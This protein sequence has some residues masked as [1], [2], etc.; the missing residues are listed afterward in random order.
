[1]IKISLAVPVLLMRGCLSSL[2]F[3]LS[4]NNAPLLR[5]LLAGLCFPPLPLYPAERGTG[6]G[7]EAS[8]HDL[9]VACTD[10]KQAFHLPQ[11][12][13]LLSFHR[14]QRELIVFAGV[15]RVLIP[16]L[17][18]QSAVGD[19]HWAMFGHPGYGLP[20]GVCSVSLVSGEPARC[21]T[22]FIFRL[23]KMITHLRVPISLT[24]CSETL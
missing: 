5:G 16:H 8:W 1:M 24:L 23:V 21:A 2:V 12:T 3:F 9:D 11:V 10:L 19:F 4:F 7:E 6:W 22:V 18:Y 13:D 15:A 17:L 14:R 20:W